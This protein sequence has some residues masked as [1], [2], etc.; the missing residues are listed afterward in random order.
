MT[1]LRRFSWLIARQETKV[2]PHLPMRCMTMLFGLTADQIAR[3]APAWRSGEE[4]FI[5]FVEQHPAPEQDWV[6]TVRL[7]RQ[8]HQAQASNTG[9]RVPNVRKG[10]RP[11]A[12]RAGAPDLDNRVRPPGEFYHL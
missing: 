2:P 4:S 3:V 9:K 8:L 6:R 1:I 7:L 10:M 5:A 12:Q 11:P